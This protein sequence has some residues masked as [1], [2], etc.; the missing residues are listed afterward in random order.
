MTLHDIGTTINNGIIFSVV[1]G[2]HIH[3]PIP[4]P[5]ILINISSSNNL[6]V[7]DYH[8]RR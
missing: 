8:G 4:D 7:L 3:V 1:V 5:N 2:L 6:S